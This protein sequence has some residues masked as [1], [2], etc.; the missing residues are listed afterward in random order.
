MNYLRICKRALYW[1]THNPRLFLDNVLCQC[2]G[3][4]P[5]KLFI[6]WHF[7]LLLGYKLDLKHPKTF[8]EKLQWLKFNDIRPEYTK[9][10][11]KVEAK[12]YVQSIIGSKYIIPTLG[13]WDSVD[14]IDWESLPEQFVVK[15][16][17]DSG[18]VVV[19][20]D[21]QKL[22]IEEAKKKL[23]TLGS[24][25]YT[26]IS[27]EYPYKN[28]PHRYIAEAYVEDESGYE[29]KDY[30]IFCFDGEP[31]FLFVATGRQ[32]HDTRF[33][34]YDLDFNHL[35]VLNGHANA[36]VWPVKPENFDEML[37]VARKLSQ[38]IPHVRVDLYNVRG[39]IYFGELTFF[40]W[41]GMVPYEPQ[42][43]DYRFGE[44]L[45]LP[46]RT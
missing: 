3:I 9:M 2:V 12:D 10:V 11:D 22:N 18:G 7:R 37:E 19:C 46:N 28:V 5:D 32:Q 40:H 44:Y 34:F 8:N 36:D 39:K 30:K 25:D 31:R 43:W 33:D 26:A 35:P 13:I 1:L 16:T 4:L 24:R 41:S 27:K 6:K 20:K 45:K 15:S 42:E 17:G 23:Q 14:K 29:L 38:G 21:K